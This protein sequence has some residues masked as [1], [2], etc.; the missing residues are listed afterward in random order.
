LSIIEVCLVGGHMQ[1]FQKSNIE[2]TMKEREQILE[3]ALN[4]ALEKSSPKAQPVVETG[5]HYIAKK[6]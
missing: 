2:S 1:I 5:I 3:N 4:Y 6:I